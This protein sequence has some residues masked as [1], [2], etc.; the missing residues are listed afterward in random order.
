MQVTVISGLFAVFF[1]LMGSVFQG[2]NFASKKDSR[3][4]VFLF[5]GVHFAQGEHDLAG[6]QKRPRSRD[7]AVRRHHP[8]AALPEAGRQQH[9]P[10]RGVHAARAFTPE[11]RRRLLHLLERPR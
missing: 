7:T 3:Q 4:L 8:A 2:M 5:G 6:R 10:V 11:T 9:P 1:Y